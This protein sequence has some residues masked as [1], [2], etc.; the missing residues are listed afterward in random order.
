MPQ[1]W[2]RGLVLGSDGSRTLSSDL[3]LCLVRLSLEGILTGL[4]NHL[5]VSSLKWNNIPFS[6]CQF[7]FHLL[8][9]LPLSSLSLFSFLLS[10]HSLSYTLLGL[11]VFSCPVCQ[12]AFLPEPSVCQGPTLTDRQRDHDRQDLSQGPVAP[13]DCRGPTATLLGWDSR[14]TKDSVLLCF[15]NSEYSFH[16]GK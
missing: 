14:C 10:L 7:V 4:V 2:K 6:L 3:C 15:L 9:D 16:F 1:V 5:Q 13:L 8:S 11:S 12:R